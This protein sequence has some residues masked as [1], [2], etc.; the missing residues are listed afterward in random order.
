M[1]CKRLVRRKECPSR[2]AE[3]SV[4]SKGKAR[5][6]VPRV[7]FLVI[8]RIEGNGNVCLNFLRVN[9]SWVLMFTKIKC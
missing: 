9:Q 3:V 2:D 7:L 5:E 6:K 4:G 1:Q 8:R